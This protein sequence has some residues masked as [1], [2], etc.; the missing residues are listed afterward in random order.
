VPYGFYSFIFVNTIISN[1]SGEWKEGVARLEFTKERSSKTLW[2]IMINNSSL[3]IF[4]R[5]SQKQL[6]TQFVNEIMHGM[7][8]SPFE[9]SAILDSVY[10]VYGDYFQS[11]GTLRPGQLHFQ[12]LCIENNPSI[13]LADSKQVT[14]TLTLDDPKEDLSIREKFGV[15]GLRLHR[16]QRLC[17]EAFQQGGL[18]TVEDL[19]YRLLNCGQRTLCRDLRS[20]REQNIML[21]LRST[22]KDMGRTISHRS[23]IIKEW[24]KGKEYSDITKDTFHSV[25][26][27]QNYVNKFKKVVALSEEGYDV[28]TIGFLVKIS[29]QLVEEYFNIYKSLDMASH[30]RKELKSFLKKNIFYLPKDGARND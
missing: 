27:V 23:L 25:A 11:N 14:V 22:I 12:V 30:R 16:I 2:C 6:N 26:S 5:L 28:H 3:Q 17:D 29:A 10:K 13:K 7:Q 18:L 20:L 15:I 8:C 4:H 19:A 9:A 1:F 24:L 21:P